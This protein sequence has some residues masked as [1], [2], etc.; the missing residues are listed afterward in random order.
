MSEL[1][2]V[3]YCP[4]SHSREKDV[5]SEPPVCKKV[6]NALNFSAIWNSVV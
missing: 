5:I 3:P 2:E 1:K 6:S 4:P